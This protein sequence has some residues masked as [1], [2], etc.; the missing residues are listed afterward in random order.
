LQCISK[1]STCRY[2]LREEVKEWTVVNDPLTRL[3]GYVRGKGLCDQQQE[4]ALKDTERLAVMAALE[5]RL[6]L[7]R[8]LATV[9]VVWWLCVLLEQAQK[10]CPFYSVSKLW[11]WRRTLLVCNPAHAAL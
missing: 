6:L 4:Q 3:L 10:P 8:Y 1:R 5:V 7:L 9:T 2:R 11:R